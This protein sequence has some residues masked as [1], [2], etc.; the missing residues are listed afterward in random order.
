[1]KNDGLERAL[2]ETWKNKEKFYEDTKGLSMTEIIKSVED[3]YKTRNIAYSKQKE[4]AATIIP[5]EQW[6]KSKK[7]QLG[8]LEGKT[9]VTFSE[10]FSM[11][12]EELIS[13]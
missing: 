12:D 11:T 5:Y 10:D 9:T 3:K 13:Q 4:T 2:E 8:T 1:L 7:R 6:K